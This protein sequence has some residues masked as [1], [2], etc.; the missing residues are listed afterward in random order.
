MV[1]VMNGGRG[2]RCTDLLLTEATWRARGSGAE[3]KGADE[4][5][6]EGVFFSFLEFDHL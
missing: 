6:A 1:D 5:R 4:S 3:G 2:L